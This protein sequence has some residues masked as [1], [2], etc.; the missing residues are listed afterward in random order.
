MDEWN[1]GMVREFGMDMY[2]LLSLKMEKQQGPTVE[3]MELC[4]L[5][6]GSLDERGVWWRMDT[7]LCMGEF[8]C[9]PPEIITTL[10]I[11]F[12]SVTQLSPIL[13]D[14]MDCSMQG[15]PVLHQFPELT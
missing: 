3:H 2:T 12:S 10:L 4:S 8:H 14:P 13:C 6:C 5:L 11:Q 15:F 7:C 9:C 1:E